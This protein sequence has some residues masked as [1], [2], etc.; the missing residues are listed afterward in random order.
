MKHGILLAACLFCTSATPA[1]GVK[2][3]RRSEA[4]EFTYS[5][6]AQAARVP[7]ID[8]MMRN[9]AQEA[10][11]RALRSGLE[12]QQVYQ[13]QQRASIRDRYS[14]QWTVSGQ[15]ARLLS[16][17][18]QL[19]TFT[20]GAHSNTS[21]GA[22]LWDR[23]MNREQRVPELFIHASDFAK[24]ARTAYCEL[25]DAERFKR[26]G[27][28]KLGGEFDQCPR[29]DDLAIAPVDRD[30]NGRFDGFDFVASPYIAGPYAEGEYEI[31][32]PVTAK[33][34]SSLKPGYRT[35]FETQRQ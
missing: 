34:V 24:L 18:K 17:Q 33:M 10:Y 16:L 26:R 28:E 30:S 3:V 15:S 20:G 11:G 23:R 14:M 13:V 1:G 29:F 27:G 9:S 2:I 32:L 6:P 31:L 22:L 21:F 7:A 8:R 25:L 4:L 12:N 19:A 5:W 35:S